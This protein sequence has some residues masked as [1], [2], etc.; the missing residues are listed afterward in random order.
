LVETRRA[1][2]PAFFEIANDALPSYR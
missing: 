2:Q 1:I